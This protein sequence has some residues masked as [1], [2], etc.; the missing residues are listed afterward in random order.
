MGRAVVPSALTLPQK[1]PHGFDVPV[2][3]EAPL[4]VATSD[5]LM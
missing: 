4:I 3:T 5:L 1:I 2:G